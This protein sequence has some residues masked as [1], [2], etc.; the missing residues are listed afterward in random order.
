MNL[1]W[2]TDFTVY[3]HQFTYMDHV[4]DSILRDVGYHEG[5]D[6]ILWDYVERS[7]FI[8]DEEP[9]YWDVRKKKRVLLENENTFLIDTVVREQVENHEVPLQTE[10]VFIAPQQFGV[11]LDF[12]RR[13]LLEK[14]GWSIRYKGFVRV[15][16]GGKM[17]FA[18]CD[19][20]GIGD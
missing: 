17:S 7:G 9:L 18:V 11:D 20:P 8:H 10:A 3:N 2:R 4:Y 6:V 16:F 15:P 12:A 5:M 19:R 14:Y 1:N 13:Y